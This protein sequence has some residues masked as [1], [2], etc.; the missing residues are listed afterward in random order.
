MLYDRKRFG[1]FHNKIW[2]IFAQEFVRHWSLSHLREEL[3]LTPTDIAN[4]HRHRARAGEV[5]TCDK[6]ESALIRKAIEHFQKNKANQEIFD[7]IRQFP[8][9]FVY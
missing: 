6:I 1:I 7:L 5:K 3:I 4:L 8:H 9:A 2:L